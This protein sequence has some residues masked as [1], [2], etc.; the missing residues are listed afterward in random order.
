MKEF[1]SLREFCLLSE[2]CP[3][4]YRYP[5][6]IH[7]NECLD[8]NHSAAKDIVQR[9]DIAKASWERYGDGGPPVGSRVRTL[10]SGHGGGIGVE[11]IFGGEYEHDKREFVIQRKEIDYGFDRTQVREKKSLVLKA[12]WWAQIRVIDGDE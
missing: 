5:R 1:Y 9:Y 11:G 2:Q 4:E 8:N 12:F 3:V 10:Q 7:K 6:S